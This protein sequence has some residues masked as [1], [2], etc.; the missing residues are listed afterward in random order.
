MTRYGLLSSYVAGATALWLVGCTVETAVAD[1]DSNGAGVGTAASA[2]GASGISTGMASGGNDAAGGN[3]TGGNNAGGTT[4][5]GGSAAGGGG[6]GEPPFG[7]SSN[8]DGGP[9]PANGQQMQAGNVSYSLLAPSA[10]STPVPLLIVFS[11][12]EGGAV[13]T[14]NLQQV[15]NFTNSNGFIRAVLDGVVYNAQGSAGATVLDAVRG[16]YDIDNDRTYLMGESAGTTAALQL[17]FE[18]RQSYFAAYW[19]NDI[20]AA[21]SPGVGASALGFAPWGQVGPGGQQGLALQIVT[22]MQMAS[23]RTDAVAPYAGAGNGTHGS[24]D[25]FLAAV[26]GFSGKT[27]Q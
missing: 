24:P 16:L 8:G 1:D 4:G 13:M 18:L 7:G 10:P 19:A 22:A 3:N 23:Y 20:V 11:G 12:T 9:T 14:N 17:G 2:G 25:Q 26:S 21:G 5:A 27:R 6:A 15:A